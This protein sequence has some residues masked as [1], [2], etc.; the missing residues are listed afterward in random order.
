MRELIKIEVF[1]KN[2]LEI[3]TEELRDYEADFEMLGSLKVGNQNRQTHIRFRKIDD[4]ESFIT[5]VDEDYVAED[6]IFNVSI[7]NLDTPQFNLV[8]RSQ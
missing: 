5:S 1:Y 4:Y 3:E 7:Y 6:A 8:N 2:L